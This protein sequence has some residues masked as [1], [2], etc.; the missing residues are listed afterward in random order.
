MEPNELENPIENNST[1]EPKAEKATTPQI[2][3]EARMWG[4]IKFGLVCFALIIFYI[5]NQHHANK[6]LRKKAELTK[7]LKE[8]HSEKISLESETTNAAKQS[9]VAKKL[10]QYGVKELTRPPSK[11]EDHVRKK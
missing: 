7:S 10:Q 2:S 1:A 3:E 9:E 6:A 5:Y 8:L 4:W 11:I